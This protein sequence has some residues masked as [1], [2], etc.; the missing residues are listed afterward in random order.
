MRAIDVRCGTMV[1]DEHDGEWC[2]AIAVRNFPSGEWNIEVDWFT[3]RGDFYLKN[4][5]CCNNDIFVN[6]IPVFHLK[7]ENM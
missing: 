4:R 5:Y 2:L 6:N 3:S 7:K 1:Y